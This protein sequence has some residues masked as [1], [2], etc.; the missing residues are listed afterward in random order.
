MKTL[1]WLLNLDFEQ[2]MNETEK[3]KRAKQIAIIAGVFTAFVGVLLLLNYLQIKKSDPLNS[4]VLEKLVERLSSEPNNQQFVE[5]IRQVDLLMRKAYFTSLWQVRTGAYLMLFGAIVLVLSL[6]VYY[7]LRFAIDQPSAEQIKEKKKR[8]LTQR[9]IGFSGALVII[10]AV[11]S[12]FFTMNHLRNYEPEKMIVHSKAGDESIEQLEI[13]SIRTSETEIDTV[14]I[15]ESTDV[16]VKQP[17]VAITQ[18]PE[19]V[20]FNKE[21]VKKNHNAFRGSWGNAVSSSTKLPTSWDGATGKNILWKTEL[22]IHGYNSPVIWNEKLFLSGANTSK[23]VVY[24]YDRNSGKL[25][26]EREVNNIQGSPATQPKTTEDTGLAA[27]TLTVDGEKVFAIFGNGDIIAFDLNGNRVWAI[28]LGVPDNHYGH[29]SSLLTWEKKLFIQYDTHS[30]SKVMALSTETG[31]TIWETVRTNDVSWASP[32]LAKVDGKFQLIMLANPNLSGYDINTGK[33]LWS[34]DCMSGEVGP[35]PVYGGGLVYATNEYAR[36]VAVN[37]K[38]GEKVWEDNYYLPEVSSPAYHNGYIYIATTFAVVACFEA[39]TG[40]FLWEFDAKNSF[41]SSPMIAEGK[42]WVF[43]T[44]G[45]AYIFESGSEP[46]L[47]SSPELGE[48]VF[49][50]PVFADGRVYIRGVKHLYCIGVN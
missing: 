31:K 30:G 16:E 46:K 23:R 14:I 47:I 5:E 9:W 11:M 3:I 7:G 45:K 33:Q 20:V 42:V 25:L 37:P 4:L 40:K 26:W 43:D 35:S 6:R 8:Q 1:K 29:S 44:G 12:A 24:C 49:A 50:T 21:T 39:A 41:Y 15:T 38:T 18:Q 27:P 48:K 36:M 19:M 34:V 22:P 17:E 32:I 2:Q 13:V 10:L 28:N